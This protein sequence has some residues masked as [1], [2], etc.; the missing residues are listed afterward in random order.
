MTALGHGGGNIGTCAYMVY[1]PD[2]EV[3]IAVMVNRCFSG[4]ESRIVRDLSRITALSL[5]PE[6]YYSDVLRSPL[7][8]AAGLWI[9]A[10][11]GAA[12]YGVRKDKSV[13]LLVFGGL[14]LVAG[15]ISIGKWSPLELVLFPVGGV[16]GALGL[17]LLLR[18]RVRRPGAS[19]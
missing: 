1:L 4:C 11:V 8:F 2:Y 15:W 14:A 7:G 12:I 16:A 9:V 5:R 18:R 6:R 3:S 19:R 13:H 17:T 10:G